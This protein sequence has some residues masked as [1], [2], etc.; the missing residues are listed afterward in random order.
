MRIIPV[1][2][3]TGAGAGVG[4]LC[5]LVPV[6]PIV[7][8]T[9]AAVMGLVIGA[10]AVVVLVLVSMQI[11]MQTGAGGLGAVSFG[12][13]EAII[14]GTPALVVVALASYFALRRLGWN[15]ER[16]A[17]RGPIIVGAGAAL[18]VAIWLTRT[19]SMSG[20]N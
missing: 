4:W 15:P 18:I 12:L 9:T 16:V 13:P 19:M 8:L 10:I 14:L 1:L 3:A 6:W 11:S 2:V 5:G 7:R 20:G 17:T